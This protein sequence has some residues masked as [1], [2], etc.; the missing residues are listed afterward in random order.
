MK[1]ERWQRIEELYHAALDRQGSERIRF[2]DKETAGDEELRREVDSLLS[3]DEQTGE[4]LES[5]AMVEAARSI[6][7]DSFAAEGKKEILTRLFS[8]GDEGEDV[9]HEIRITTPQGHTRSLALEGRRLSLGRSEA[10]DLSFP[11]D[12]GL[13]RRH[14]IFELDEDQWSVI[15]LGSKNGTCVNGIRITGKQNLQPSDRITASCVTVQ[16]N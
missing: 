15:D 3:F 1:P 8:M 12:D 11:E 13:S 9:A 5:T 7:G 10:N 2:L 16:F 4:F 6:T 14:L